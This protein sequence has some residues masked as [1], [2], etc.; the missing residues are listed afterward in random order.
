MHYNKYKKNP[1]LSTIFNKNIY[2]I[3]LKIFALAIFVI[4]VLETCSVAIQ[5]M[6]TN[7]SF[8]KNVKIGSNTNFAIASDQ[9]SSWAYT[10]QINLNSTTP[11]NNYQIK[12]ELTTSNFDYSKAN[13]NG[14]DIRFLDSSGSFYNYWIQNWNTTGTSTIWVEVA[15]AGTKTFYMTYGNP[16]A[17][18]QSNGDK[19]F[20]FFDDFSGPT[21]N[22]TNWGFDSDQY[23]NYSF[24]QGNL[25]LRSDTPSDNFQ[26]T[27]IGFDNLTLYHDASPGYYDPESALTGATHFSTDHLGNITSSAWAVTKINQWSTAEI[28]WISS[29]LVKY[30]NN[31]N[32]ISSTNNIPDANLRLTISAFEGDGGWGYGTQ[33]YSHTLFKEGDAVG[34]NFYSNASYSPA[35]T[36]IPAFSET[37]WIYV[38]HVSALEPIVTSIVSV[39]NPPTSISNPSSSISNSGNAI[40]TQSLSLDLSFILLALPIIVFLK[41]K[42]QK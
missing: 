32:V 19:T 23:S 16:S 36:Y 33:V 20:I 35:V 42:N 13:A 40:K 6:N 8:V 2:K 28:Q 29:S 39:S 17:T 3:L 37:N 15:T 34:F 38:R 9:Q 24:Y 26:E 1:N 18:S 21:L 12:V 41:R 30:V 14:N 31:T 10:G 4:L 25:A 5:G 11:L 22:T 7:N 27:G